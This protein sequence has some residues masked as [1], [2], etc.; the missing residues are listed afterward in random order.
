MDRDKGLWLQDIAERLDLLLSGMARHVDMSV[1]AVMDIGAGRYQIVDDPRH[2]RFVSGYRGCRDD[3]SV[4]GV[5]LDLAM[6]PR[7]H[8]RQG[9]K[10]FTLA[11]RAYDRRLLRI[12]IGEFL[13]LEPILGWEVE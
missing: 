2:L 11:T 6:L 5:Q 3:H 12:Q 4:I 13:D 10:R 1:A 9:G 8:E 7:G